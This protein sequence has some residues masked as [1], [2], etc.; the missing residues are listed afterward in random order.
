MK[1][2]F[3][4]IYAVMFYIFRI[5]P[6]RENKITLV[7]PHNSSFKDGLHE[8]EEAFKKR[9][10]YVFCYISSKDLKSLK[11][12]VRYFTK[13]VFSLATSKFIFLNDNFMPMANLS[14][15][16]KTKVIQLW[17]GQGAFKK[18]GLDTELAK[19]VKKIALK[20][21]EKYDY[22]TVSSEKVSEVFQRAFGVQK[23]KILSLGNPSA[24]YFFLKRNNNK[25][26]KTYPE[27]QNKKLILYAPTF[28]DDEKENAKIFS[29]F[30]AEMFHENLSNEYELLV[31]L[32]PQ[33]H[34]EL[35]FENAV[36]VTD[37]DDVNELLC[38]SDILITDY[39]SICMEFSLLKKPMIF[40]PYDYDYFSGARSFYCDYETYV[41][42]KVVKTMG[43]LINAIKNEDF[44]I[45]KQ[46]EFR[47]KNFDYFDNKSAERLVDFLLTNH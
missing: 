35:N 46:E 44:E 33:I 15:S 25:F 1:K 7:S 32:H 28:R 41:P 10:E 18:F 26:F 12:V 27:L 45:E 40:F 36:N 42:G 38:V 14:F 29:N 37:Y 20:C 3:Y 22:I 47:E 19:D 9:G 4:F 13:N 34:D 8:V 43:E 31:R 17:H 23:N 21:A 39:S 24:D 11:G 16:K 2:F 30:S 5:F 6:V